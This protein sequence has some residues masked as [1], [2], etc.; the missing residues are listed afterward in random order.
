MSFDDSYY[1]WTP[2]GLSNAV[3]PPDEEHAHKEC[4]ESDKWKNL[5]TKTS[6]MKPYFV[7]NLK[8]QRFLKL[9][10]INESTL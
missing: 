5:I 3:E 1:V 7:N 10:K 9:Q 2:Y 8:R 6:Y 4:Y